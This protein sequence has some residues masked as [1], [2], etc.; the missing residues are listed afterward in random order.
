MLRLPRRVLPVLRLLQVVI[1]AVAVGVGLPLPASAHDV[2]IASSPADGSTV[3]GTLET[4]SFT[5]DQPVQ[6]FQP[7]IAVTGPDG[8]QYQ[9]GSPQVL[10]SVVSGSVAPGPAGRYI[11]AYRIVSADGHPVTGQITFT[12]QQAGSGTGVSGS[13]TAGVPAETSTAAGGSDAGSD[14]RSTGGLSAWLWIGIG[15][16]AVLIAA[17]AVILLRKPAKR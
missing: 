15:V 6:N 8:K 9:T 12:L 17:A 4:V 13:G 11:A 7:A 2:L 16:A 10:G 1:A 5:F 3:T 14:G